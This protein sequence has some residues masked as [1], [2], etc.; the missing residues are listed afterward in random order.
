M[1]FNDG[2]VL[3]SDT[4][5]LVCGSTGIS[6]HI[7]ASQLDGAA[8][9]EQTRG[10]GS[11]GLSNNLNG[12]VLEV[13]LLDKVLGA[14]NR[15]GCESSVSV[16]WIITGLSRK[17]HLLHHWSGSSSLESSER[18]RTN[19]AICNAELSPGRT[20]LARNLLVVQDL[21]S[22]H[23]VAELRVR[24]VDRVPVVLGGCKKKF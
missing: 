23:I 15:T 4:S 21:L 3:G 19:L 11:H 16:A 12:L 10:V 1:Q 13:V 2:E 8:V 18:S 20:Y 14:D 22:G 9:I 6:G 24:V 5:L 7:R 17:T